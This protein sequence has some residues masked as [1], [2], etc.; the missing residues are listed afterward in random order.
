MSGMTSGQR[1]CSGEHNPCRSMVKERAA[2]LLEEELSSRKWRPQLVMMSGVTDCYQPIE[3]KMQLT[4]RCLQVLA[5]FRN[6]VGILTKNRLVMRDID[7]FR[8]LADHNCVAANLSITSLDPNLQRILEPRT[9]PPAA[10]LE[11]V[12]DLRA[13]GIP[14]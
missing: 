8:E 6:P 2:E 14:L 12:P 9:P 5:K 11:A 7:V 4:R 1:A 10:R 3:R 13:A